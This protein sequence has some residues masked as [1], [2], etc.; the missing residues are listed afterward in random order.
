[1]KYFCIVLFFCTFYF[2][3]NG[4]EKKIDY[5]KLADNIISEFANRVRKSDG[6]V[7]Y[8]KGGQMMDDI[9]VIDLDFYSDKKLNIPLARK[10]IIEKVEEFLILM[11]SNIT[12]R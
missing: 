4:K 1:M 10:L 8:G 7:L 2:S 12:I 6:L 5:C 9:K 3:L 11:N